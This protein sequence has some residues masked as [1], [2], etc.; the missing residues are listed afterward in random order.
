MTQNGKIPLDQ[1]QNDNKINSVP[2]KW[3]S[4]VPHSAFKYIA[5]I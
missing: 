5:R 4:K 3:E 1:L 2:Q